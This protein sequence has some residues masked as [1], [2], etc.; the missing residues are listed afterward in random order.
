[1]THSV[2]KANIWIL[3][4]IN[5]ITIGADSSC[6]TVKANIWISVIIITIT[7]SADSPCSKSQY[8]NISYNKYYFRD[9]CNKQSCIRVL[10]HP[11]LKANI[12]ILVLINITIEISVISPAATPPTF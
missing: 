3:A 6:S 12:W 5:I 9:K 8:L 4:I 10:T 1:M 2:L 7:I 11:V